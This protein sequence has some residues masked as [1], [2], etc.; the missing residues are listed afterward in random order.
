MGE[1]GEMIPRA[2]VRT[3][4]GVAV[5]GAGLVLL[6]P[7]A[8]A[9]PL[10]V[11]ATADC[12]GTVSWETWSPDERVNHYIE[13]AAFADGVGDPVYVTN[14]AFNAQ[15]DFFASGTFDYPDGAEFVRVQ[16]ESLSGWGGYGEDTYDEGP[17]SVDVTTPDCDDPEESTTTTTSTTLP[18][19]VLAAGAETPVAAPAPQVLASAPAAPI[20]TTLAYTGPPLAVPLALF[21][22]LM[23]MAGLLL[24]LAYPTR[25]QD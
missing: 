11:S 2:L 22:G 9:E 20:A 19:E 15:N 21:G 1:K 7:A 24:R 25:R 6:A 17:D 12:E 10:D 3:A 18:T 8:M 13:V 16:V 4:V 5:V 14:I 23:L